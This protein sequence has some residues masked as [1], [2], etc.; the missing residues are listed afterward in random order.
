MVLQTHDELVFE[1]REEDVPLAAEIIREMM[2]LPL[3]Y[4]N[5]S[6]PVDMKVTEYW[7]QKKEEGT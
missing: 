7:G 1:T 3:P 5:L 6:L 2:E 4:L